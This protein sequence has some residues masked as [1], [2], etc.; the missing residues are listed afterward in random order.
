MTIRRFEL[1]DADEN[2]HK[3]WEVSDPEGQGQGW[4]VTCRWGRVGT[5]GQE[6]SFFFSAY[7]EANAFRC[8]K[9]DEKTGKGYLSI[10]NLIAKRTG[11]PLA[12][13]PPRCDVRGCDKPGEHPCTCTSCETKKTRVTVCIDHWASEEARACHHMPTPLPPLDPED[14]FSLPF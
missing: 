1:H 10:G 5:G 11:I 9:I 8:R 12:Q 14:P 2:H 13:E 6:R 7:A 4:I 3:Y